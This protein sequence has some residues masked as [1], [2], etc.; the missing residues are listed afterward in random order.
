MADTDWRYRAGDVEQGPITA[1]DLCRLFA[2]GTLRLDT[3]VWCPAVDQW[4]QAATIPGFRQAAAAAPPSDQPVVVVPAIP[5]APN[6]FYQNAAKA[7]WA[8]PL[9]AIG[10]TLVLAAGA[11]IVNHGAA[12][13]T[14]Q[15]INACISGGLVLCG[16][17]AGIMAL[18]GAGT[19]RK[20]IRNPAI[21][22]VALNGLIILTGV[23]TFSSARAASAHAINAAQLYR[24]G[25][26]SAEDFPG[27]IGPAKLPGGVVV[28]G[29]LDDQSPTARQVL[30]ELTTPCSVVTITISNIASGSPLTIDPS[31]LRLLSTQGTIDALASEDVLA[32]AHASAIESLRRLSSSQVVPAGQQACVTLCFIPRDIDLHQVAAVTLRIN[33]QKLT[34]PGR[35]FSS[36]EKQKQLQKIPGLQLPANVTASEGASR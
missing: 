18:M 20:Q 10:I 30:D 22:G 7:A 24:E 3:V 15:A 6:N 29:T 36:Q 8:A 14:S 13:T 35:Y 28:V 12:H 2:A 27:W 21:V 1:E 9:L 11:S 26:S 33:G 32:T 23:W 4:V 19:S 31:S 25:V 17:F 16:F 5:A 34:I